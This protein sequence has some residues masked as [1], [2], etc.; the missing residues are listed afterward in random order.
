[1]Y[2]QLQ[3][4]PVAHI[5]PESPSGQAVHMF[6]S[7]KSQEAQYKLQPEKEHSM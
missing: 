5:A 6:S 4:I 2:V 3:Y 7:L 1:M